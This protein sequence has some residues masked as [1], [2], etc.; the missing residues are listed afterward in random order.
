MLIHQQI[1]QSQRLQQLNQMAITQI[2]S[3]LQNT[4]LKKLK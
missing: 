1:P 2:K 4:Q 3:L